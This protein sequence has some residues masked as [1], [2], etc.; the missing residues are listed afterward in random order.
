MY[1]KVVLGLSV[2]GPFDYIVPGGLEGKI[3]V[4][5]RVRVTLRKKKCIGY[6]VGL[7]HETQIKN[8]LSVSELIDELPL[9]SREMLMLTRELSDY[10]CSSWGEAIETALP[11]A[12][13]RG[14]KLS[15]NAPAGSERARM[16]ERRNI[17]LV[18][19]ED[20]RSRWDF[21]I[22]GI[23]EELARKKEVIILLPDIERVRLAAE[24]V[25]SRT[26]LRPTVL[27]RQGPQEIGDWLKIKE[28]G[29]Q[30]IVGSRSAVFAPCSRLGLVIIDEE[31]DFAYKQDQVPH[32]HAREVAFMRC[33]IE[34][35]ALILGAHTPSLESLN[36]A[37]QGKIAHLL[38]P[39]QG[40]Y[41]AVSISDSKTLPF[42]SL[43]RRGAELSRDLEEAVN[44]AVASGGKAL[45]FLNRKGF[46]TFASCSSCH[47]VFRCP[48]C[49]INLVYH[50][51]DSTL[52]CHYCNYSIPA[53]KVCPEC[54]SGYIK[55][56]G[57]GTEKMESELSRIF[58]KARV[59]VLSD[60][61]NPDLKGADIFI[62]TESILKKGP[63]FEL[64][65]VLSIDNSLNR[66]DLRAAEKTFRLLNGLLALTKEKLFVQ[67]ALPRHHA[68]A[69]LSEK[70]TG[71]FYDQELKQRKQL[72]F[73][74]YSH[75]GLVKVRGKKE[76]R[77]KEAAA[78][79]FEGLKGR[80][81]G[82]QIKIIALRE[83]A[84]AK[85]RG[86]FYWQILLNSRS[87]E[88]IGAFLKK[89][90]KDLR[91]SGIIVTVDVD[92]L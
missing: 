34:K 25:Y 79:L 54:N 85:L 88:K 10:Y 32:Y 55:Y 70:D 89:N 16:K 3:A 29:S 68:F 1:A 33:R 52:S 80:N 24:T 45:F 74:P 5:S 42:G 22:A 12:L 78:A 91:Y 49:N 64:V 8:I 83:G 53:P 63:S 26:G 9:I 72:N 56:S 60:S 92:P 73:P 67:T 28:G 58:P 90:L 69:A 61:S 40:A 7:S 75:L 66:I 37:F 76:S 59:K 43:Q 44:A 47:A 11:E 57:L 48:R 13:R 2:E 51:K 18:Q 31:D 84:P 87:A 81:K 65:A 15:F 19:D 50:F 27:L 30:V 62:A 4:G 38:L 36:L 46:A 77:V 39:R 21:Y 17:L 23:K 41:P 14:R 82:R 86:N 6:V 71:I 20:G 35:A